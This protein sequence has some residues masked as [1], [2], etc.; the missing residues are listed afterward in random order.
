MFKQQ[1]MK[2]L[3]ISRISI[4]WCCDLFNLGIF[5]QLGKKSLVF[6]R[7]FVERT[8]KEVE[9]EALQGGLRDQET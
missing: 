4:R 3:M 9:E 2:A 1:I 6:C 8:K 5:E 7:V